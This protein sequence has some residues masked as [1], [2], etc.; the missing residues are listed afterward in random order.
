MGNHDFN[1]AHPASSDHA[2]FTTDHA[3]SS[4]FF[5]SAHC[6]QQSQAALAAF[7]ESL[8]K[9][10]PVAEWKLLCET[11]GDIK[12]GKTLVYSHATGQCPA[13]GDSSAPGPTTGGHADPKPNQCN[14]QH[15]S[16]CAFVG[17]RLTT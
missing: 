9:D 15:E 17:A 1:H 7:R 11:G 5:D 4:A 16:V 13:R 3:F 8:P 6:S 2:Q 12:L 14:L 10:D